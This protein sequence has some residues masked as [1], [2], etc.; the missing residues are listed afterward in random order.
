MFTVD[1]RF[2]MFSIG[3]FLQHVATV[4]LLNSDFLVGGV[5]IGV[6]LGGGG[7]RGHRPPHFSSFCCYVAKCIYFSLL[8]CDLCV[9][10]GSRKT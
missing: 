6:I 7:L 2:D 4:K 10:Y 3:N 5:F 1:S 8:I 9:K